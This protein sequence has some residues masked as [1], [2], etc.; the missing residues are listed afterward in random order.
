MKVIFTGASSFTGSWFAKELADC[1]HEVMATFRGTLDS[2]TGLRRKRI[3]TL[4]PGVTPVWSCSF[5][6]E[7]FLDV[8]TSDSWDALCHHGAFADDY[9]SPSFDVVRAV[10]SNASNV[11]CVL[12]RLATGGT[13]TLLLTGSVF[14]GGEGAGSDGLTAFSPYG[15]S[16]ELTWRVFEFYA[17]NCGVNLG[18][19]VIPNPFGPY[20]E[21]RFT[22]YLIRTWKKRE[23]AIVNTPDYV[24]DNI[25][26]DLLAN[27]YR[28]YLESL[29]EIDG[30]SRTNP[31]GYV[32]KQ[33]EF[34]QRFAAEMR[35]RLG[36]KC[37]LRLKDQIDFSEPMVRHNTDRVAP[38]D[39]S[40]SEAWDR[41]AEFYR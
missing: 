37:E 30:V 3:E 9:K 12:D 34:A 13:R 24:R 41:V 36:Y 39:W 16:K 20:E 10:A 1:G 22:A 40:E 38:L 18:K 32:E 33:G 7:R 5:G 31:S 27:A 6:D 19:F 11:Q 14:E 4:L 29:P 28:L 26:I 2:Y 21:P 35:P 25:H 8:A 23:A 17:T 15:L